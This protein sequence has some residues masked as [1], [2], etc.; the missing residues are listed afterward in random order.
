MTFRSLSVADGELAEAVERYHRA[1]G[2][3]LAERFLMSF[4]QA[5]D[6]VTAGPETFPV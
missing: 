6:R 2:G 4:D 1:G 3:S 5:V